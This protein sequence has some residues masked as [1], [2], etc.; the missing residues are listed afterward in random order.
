[1]INYDKEEFKNFY[2]KETGEKLTDK[3]IK[4]TEKSLFLKLTMGLTK[5]KKET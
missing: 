5:N 1:M 4:E 3:E 2:L